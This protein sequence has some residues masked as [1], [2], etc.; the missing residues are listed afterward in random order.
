MKGI[1]RKGMAHDCGC[2]RKLEMSPRAINL[3]GSGIG[4]AAVD[5]LLGLARVAVKTSRACRF[6]YAQPRRLLSLR[7]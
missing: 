5:R 2:Q 1:I 7:A 6:H 4:K 3:A